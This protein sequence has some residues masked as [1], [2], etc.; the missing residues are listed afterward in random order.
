MHKAERWDSEVIHVVASAV[1]SRTRVVA[2]V[3]EGADTILDMKV[4]FA[5]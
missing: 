5:L 1:D 4:A 2:N 3:H